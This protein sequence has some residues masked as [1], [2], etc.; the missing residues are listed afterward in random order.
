[1]SRSYKVNKISEN[2]F[3]KLKEDWNS[4]LINSDSDNLFLRGSGYSIGGSH[5][6]IKLITQN[7]WF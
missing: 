7:F 3:S 1:M 6:E 4:L 2:E 5:G